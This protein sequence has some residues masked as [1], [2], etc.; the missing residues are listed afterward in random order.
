V[1]A[2]AVVAAFGGVGGQEEPSLGGC[3][4]GV[5]ML[6]GRGESRGVSMNRRGCASVTF[7]RPVM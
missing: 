4:G 6:W 2:K 3:A 7:S 5:P 1:S